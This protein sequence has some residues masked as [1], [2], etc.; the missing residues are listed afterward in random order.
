MQTID[1]RRH[2][3]TKTGERRGHGSHLSAEGVRLAQEVG[4]KLGPYAYVVASGVPRTLETAIAM[5]FAVDE[6]IDFA[7]ARLW[8]AAS[9]AIKQREPQDEGQL[10]R[11]I[12][13]LVATAG[14]VAELGSRQAELWAKIAMRLDN[15]E[16]ALVVTH[17]GLIEPGLVAALPGWAH[18]RWARGFRQCE[19]ARLTWDGA[20]FTDAVVFHLS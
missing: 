3:Y 4:A 10:Y 11:V 14:P 15:G 12:V 7:D 6:L 5:G 13:E 1:V 16:A 8:E 2:S 17:G 20:A 19:G 9:A 18:E